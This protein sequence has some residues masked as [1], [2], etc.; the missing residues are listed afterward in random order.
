MS[1]IN[2]RHHAVHPPSGIKPNLAV[3]QK[4]NYTP[5][6]TASTSPNPNPSLGQVGVDAVNSRVPAV[7]VSSLRGKAADVSNPDSPDY[8]PDDP[9]Y[10]ESLDDSE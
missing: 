7:H 10:D 1:K 2:V 5:P 3:N 4:P 6:E 9:N 8:N